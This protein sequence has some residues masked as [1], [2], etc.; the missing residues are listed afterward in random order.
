MVLEQMG[1][2]ENGPISSCAFTGHR[3]LPQDFSYSS[4]KKQVE[5]LILDGVS[6]FY[7]GMARG[8][9]LMAAKAVISLKKKYPQVKMIACIPFYN[10]EKY[11]TPLE[12]RRYASYLKKADEQAVLSE[13][14]KK[15]CLH[16]RNRYMAD[17]A[18]VLVA[19]LRENTGGTAYTVGY[20]KKKYP[21]KRVI[22]L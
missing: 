6:V 11:Y 13:H 10:Q 21:F 9:D 20:F 3:E 16:E 15:G 4:L 7:V 8:F 17:R 14:Y 1:F 22:F 18:D 2:L 19:L 12:K 5:R